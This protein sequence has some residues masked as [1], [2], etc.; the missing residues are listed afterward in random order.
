MS[1]YANIQRLLDQQLK[2]VPSNPYVSWPNAEIRPGNSALNQFVQPNLLL[3]S[4][5]LHTLKDHERIPGIYQIDIYGKLNRGVRQILTLADET[6]EHYEATRKLTQG[7]TTVFIQN[8]SLGP[9]ERQEAW[10]KTFVEVNFICYND[11]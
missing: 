9:Y 7:D 10:F 2:L 5:E 11:R 1:V 4:T 3:A 8:I 6:K